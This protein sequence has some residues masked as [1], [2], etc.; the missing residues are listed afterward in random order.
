MP[1]WSPDGTRLAFLSDREPGL[2]RQV[3]VMRRDFG[4]AERLTRTDGRIAS[5]AAQQ[6]FA[7]SPDGSRIAFLMTEPDTPSEA[8]RKRDGRDEVRFEK[9]PKYNRICVADVGTGAVE[10]ASPPRLQIWEFGWSPDGGDFVAV[11]SDGPHK[12][13]WYLAR[14]VR[15]DAGSAEATTLHQTERQ[16]AKPAWSPDG[17][18]IAFL[19]SIWSD[20]GA[21][22][23]SVF[24]MPAE[25]GD[26]TE[27]EGS[28]HTS[29]NWI[30]WSRD[31]GTLHIAG[32]ERGGCG[33][34]TLDADSGARTQLWHTEGAIGGGAWPPCSRDR[35]R[36][37]R[38]HRRGR[39]RGGGGPH[40]ET[41]RRDARPHEA[42]RP[43]PARRRSSSWAAPR[44]CTGT[45]ET[46]SAYR[47]C[48]SALPTVTATA[49][50][51]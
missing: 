44:Y 1:L 9:E 2:G 12:Y 28:R 14:L 24:V 36:Q 33:I 13:D 45:P 32:Q 23:G 4:E 3:Y 27:L 17:S 46:G 16:L 43:P 40:R 34:A 18:R 41:G 25:G 19:S 22:G 39:A 26:A 29:P 10:Y 30:E 5:S 6:T 15:F 47:G 37:L 20:Q 35:R 50:G 49:R 38:G 8:Q 42:D 21:V 48:S 51:R 11:A 7:W 31:G